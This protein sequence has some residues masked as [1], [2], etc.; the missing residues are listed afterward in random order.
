[1][2]GKGREEPKL[3]TPKSNAV[4]TPAPAA[5]VPSDSNSAIDTRE[6]GDGRLDVWMA[7]DDR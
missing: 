5:T 7:R 4:D 2:E 1:M 6:Q 3:V